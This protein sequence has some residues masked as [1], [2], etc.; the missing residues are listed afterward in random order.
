M[1]I[2]GIAY[3]IAY[4]MQKVQV[5][6]RS[7]IELTGFSNS[8]T[9]G[10]RF[11]YPGGAG[12]LY[13]TSIQIYKDLNSTSAGTYAS[14]QS[15]DDIIVDS[16]AIPANTRIS[17]CTVYSYGQVSPY[18]APTCTTQYSSST[19]AL[20]EFRRLSQDVSDMVMDNALNTAVNAGATSSL[21]IMVESTIDATVKRYIIVGRTGFVSIF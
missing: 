6:G 14:F 16:F 3:D 15:A 5:L 19:E 11:V 20:I 21:M 18:V 10:L 13:P 12:S 4:I 17:I 1:E 7:A 8:Q 2:R 9:Y